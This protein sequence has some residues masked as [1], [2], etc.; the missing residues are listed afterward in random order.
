[1]CFDFG[2]NTNQGNP[3]TLQPCAAVPNSSQ[4][5]VIQRGHIIVRATM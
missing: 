4:D 3:V 5:V 2:P 1:M